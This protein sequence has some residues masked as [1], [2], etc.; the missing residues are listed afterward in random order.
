MATTTCPKC[1]GNKTI[2]GFSHIENGVCF[3]CSGSGVITLSAER[4]AQIETTMQD[5]AKKREWLKNATA[6]QIAA[7]SVEKL[8]KAFRFAAACV[9]PFNETELL[10]AYN[11]LKRRMDTL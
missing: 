5:T 11:M 3:Q 6:G 1:C 9:G 2:S 4:S 8:V 7:L 10:P